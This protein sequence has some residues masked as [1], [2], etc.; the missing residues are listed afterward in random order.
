MAGRSV[1]FVTG[2]APELSLQLVR[3]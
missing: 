2:R 1:S 3:F